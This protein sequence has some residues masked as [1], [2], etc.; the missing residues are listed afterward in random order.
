ME[1]FKEFMEDYNTATLPHPKYY[2]FE[3][4]ENQVGTQNTAQVLNSPHRAEVVYT[5]PSG[6]FVAAL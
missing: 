3:T 6:C 1:Y 5:L 4:W 2:D